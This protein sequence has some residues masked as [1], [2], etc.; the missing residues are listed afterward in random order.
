MH[1]VEVFY[2]FKLESSKVCRTLFSRSLSVDS[3]I[4]FKR[5][6]VEDNTFPATKRR[7]GAYIYFESLSYLQLLPFSSADFVV[8]ETPLKKQVENY[9]Q[10]KLQR[11]RYNSFM[12]LSL[13]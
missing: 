6:C 4:G 3:D 13:I 5:P 2:S 9:R 10:F 8:K 11:L 1:I 7:R 12:C